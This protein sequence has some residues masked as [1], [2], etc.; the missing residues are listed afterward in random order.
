[1]RI[2]VLV[3]GQAEFRGLPHLL[4]RIV[5]PHQVLS[6]PLYCDIQPFATPAQMALAASKRFPL[7][8]RRGAN[9][10]VILVDK[11]SRPECTGELAFSIAQE[12]RLRLSRM[13]TAV[14]LAVV[15]KVTSFENWLVSDPSVLR[16]LPGLFSNPDRIE[17]Q[18]M[19]GRA[20]TVNALGLLTACS[21]LGQ[22]EKTRDSV[23]I[24]KVLD[25]ATAARNS[26]SFGKLLRVLGS[27]S[28]PSAVRRAVRTKSRR[29]K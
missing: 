17:K 27:P 23:A 11:E 14:E 16:Q 26:R 2:G 4:Q 28:A 25:P 21:K 29:R 7:L 20:D 12:A 6:Q 19:L 13:A 22:L 10:V 15:L 18:V 3:D 1:M 8:I 5:T 24:C 9:L